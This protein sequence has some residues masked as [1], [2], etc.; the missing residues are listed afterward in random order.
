[1]RPFGFGEPR[2]ERAHRQAIDV[3]GVDAGEQRLREVGGGLGAEAPRHER[4]D[5]FV[6]PSSRRAGR[7]APRPCA[8]CPASENSR[9]R[10]ERPDARRNAE[11]RRGRQRMQRAA[12]QD[13]GEPRRLGRHQAIAEAELLAELDAVRLLDEQRVGTGVDR[14]AVD[15]LAEDDAA[16]RAR[17]SSR[18]NGTPR[19]R[20]LVGRRQA[21]DAA[22]DDDDVVD[23]SDTLAIGQRLELLDSTSVPDPRAWR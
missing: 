14:E 20:E 11:H 5:R 2:E 3:A 13:E 12:A 15:L 7:R 23:M 22:T 19:R 18:T 1:M 16:R 17:A 10:D 9:V 21:G 6:A 4:A 8:A